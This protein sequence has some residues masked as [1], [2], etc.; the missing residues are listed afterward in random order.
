MAIV[1]AKEVRHPEPESRAARVTTC[2]GIFAAGHH[3]G[4]REPG[5][6]DILHIRS[7]LDRFAVSWARDDVRERAQT[8][9]MVD[10]REAPPGQK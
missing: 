4:S 2:R 8:G 5:S 6:L 1:V 3:S 9:T 7:G 10:G